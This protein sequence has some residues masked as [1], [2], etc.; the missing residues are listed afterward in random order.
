MQHY[1]LNL[2]DYWTMR[3][4]TITDAIPTPT[5]G[6]EQLAEREHRYA[7]AEKQ[8]A[9]RL[10]AEQRLQ[11]RVHQPYDGSD[12]H[13]SQGASVRASARLSAALTEARRLDCRS[14]QLLHQAEAL[15]LLLE[16]AAVEQHERERSTSAGLDRESERRAALVHRIALHRFSGAPAAAAL[17]RGRRPPDENGDWPRSA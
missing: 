1:G 9:R 14:P 10:K 16:R 4:G 11:E 7:A 15:L 17:P 3:S 5:I 6:E 8:D 2:N 12:A 13:G